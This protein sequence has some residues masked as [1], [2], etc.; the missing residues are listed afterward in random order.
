MKEYIVDVIRIGYSSHTIRINAESSEEAENKAI[1]HC[2]SNVEF[3]ESSSEYEI[4][5]CDEA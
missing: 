5:F 1:E 3:R 4:G 2:K